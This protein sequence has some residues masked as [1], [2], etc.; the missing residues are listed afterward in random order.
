[1]QS[2]NGLAENIYVLIM[3]TVNT[4]GEGRGTKGE[5]RESS[6]ILHTGQPEQTVIITLVYL[7]NKIIFCNNHETRK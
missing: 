4:E 2:L 3:K 5:G 1:M 6:C 7:Y